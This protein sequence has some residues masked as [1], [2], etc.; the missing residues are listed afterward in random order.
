MS[1]NNHL[2]IVGPIS[3]LQMPQ[4]QD[5][6]FFL[7]CLL[8][9]VKDAP[10]E[11]RQSQAHTTHWALSIFWEQLSRFQN[12]SF[13]C[14]QCYKMVYSWAGPRT[15]ILAHHEWKLYTY[16]IIVSSYFWGKSIP[17]WVSTMQRT[18]LPSARM[19]MCVRER[20]IN[21]LPITAFRWAVF[22]AFW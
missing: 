22:S 17:K 21:I 7:S 2:S 10:A 11:G 1:W 15:L 13:P 5:P 4:G 12:E 18:R 20:K 9:T 14:V 19:C 8:K 3:Q 16:T 6:G